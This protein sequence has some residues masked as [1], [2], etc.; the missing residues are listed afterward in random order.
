MWVLL[1]EHVQQR[2]LDPLELELKVVGSHMVWILWKR[3]VVLTVE[4]PLQPQF[5]D[6]RIYLHSTQQTL[7]EEALGVAGVWWGRL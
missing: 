1:C 7:V 4:L 2:A 6:L 5:P 3:E